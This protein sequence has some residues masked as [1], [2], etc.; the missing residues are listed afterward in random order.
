MGSGSIVKA[1]DGAQ[2]RVRRRWLDRPAPNLRRSFKANREEATEAGVLDG[3]FGA[4]NLTDSGASIALGIAVLLV[5]LILLPLLGVALELIALLFLVF[6]GVVA[7]VVFHR[8]WIILA[9]KLGDPEERVAFAVKGW[10]DSSQALRE[11]RTAI[12]ATG[13]PERLTVGEPLAT[14]RPT[15]SSS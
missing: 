14:K 6:S 3:I 10:R 2:W 8:P 12:A 9:E 15:A 4:P 1:A 11:L 7:R 5:I 13:P